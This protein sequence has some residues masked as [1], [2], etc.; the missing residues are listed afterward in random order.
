MRHG[1]HCKSCCWRNLLIYGIRNIVIMEALAEEWSALL[2]IRWQHRNLHRSKRKQCP[3]LEFCLS[4]HLR[5]PQKHSRYHNESQVRQDS[6]NSC[7]MGNNN[8]CLRRSAVTLPTQ[9]QH[10][11]P[12]CPHRL[13]VEQGTD[14]SDAERAPRYAK[15]HPYTSAQRLFRRC[16]AQNSKADGGF[17][18][19]ESDDIHQDPDDVVFHGVFP[20]PLI[21]IC[22]FPTEPDEMTIRRQT[23]DGHINY[24]PRM[25]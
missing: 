7:S 21:Q 5:F 14:E 4:F 17:N 1:V 6:G 24:L 19:S 16:N 9:Y 12:Y 23:N 18:E 20:L 15:K 22:F 2:K 25:R 3:C 8:E 11:R 13:A 10:R